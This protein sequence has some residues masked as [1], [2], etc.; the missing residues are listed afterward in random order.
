V[1][2]YQFEQI[3]VDIIGGFA[4]TGTGEDRVMTIVDAFSSYAI[5]V[6][7]SNESA[8]TFANV[9]YKY[10]ICVHGCPKRIVTDRAQGFIAK[11]LKHLCQRLGVKKIETS[12]YMPQANAKVERYH[13]VLGAALTIYATD[14]TKWIDHIHAVVFAY[15]TSVHATT[16]FSPYQLIY[17]RDPRLPLDLLLEDSTTPYLDETQFGL[18]ISETLRETF[19]KVRQAQLDSWRATQNT[20]N[21]NRYSLDLKPGTWVL[22]WEPEQPPKD[23]KVP[24]KM[25]YRWSYPCKVIKKAG[26]ASYQIHSP[27]RKQPPHTFNAPLS[28]LTPFSPWDEGAQ[29]WI[30]EVHSYRDAEIDLE[31][32]EDDSPDRLPKVGDLVI[33]PLNTITE[34]FAVAKILTIKDGDYTVQWYG[35]SHKNMTGTWKPGWIDPRDRR[36]YHAAKPKGNTKRAD[37][38]YT[39]RSPGATS[40]IRL[41]NITFYDFDL[42]DSDR[43]PI[44]ILRQISESKDINYTLPQ[45][46]NPDKI[47]SQLNT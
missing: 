20:R 2:S 17:G 44:K 46:R 12:G 23:Q 34:P 6:P 8:Q 38:I 1:A 43:L 32:V 16:K 37:L 47:V 9:I 15:N 31:P 22:H 4:E 10:V 13:K 45:K 42:T 36:A 35:N 29:T 24:Q 26:P 14:K 40:K 30:D 18:Q 11:V 39:N 25:L 7:V 5:A 19:K 21:K 41:D 27:W 3:H 33:I 28:K